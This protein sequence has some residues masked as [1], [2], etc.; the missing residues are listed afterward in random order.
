[1]MPAKSMYRG[2]PIEWDKDRWIYA[3]TRQSVALTHTQ[4]SCGN[5][6]R[7]ATPDGHD[8]CLGTLPNVMNACCGHGAPNKAYIQYPGGRVVSGLK[9]LKLITEALAIC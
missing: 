4:R 5:C 9:A 2:R 8:A 6:G 7:H 3:D 1:M